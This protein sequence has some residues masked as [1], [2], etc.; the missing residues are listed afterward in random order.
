[1]AFEEGV[2]ATDVPSLQKMGLPLRKVATLISSVFCEQVFSSGF[3][4]CDPHEANVLI[5]G[6]HKGR[7]H[8]PVLVLLDHGL[9]KEL[10]TE[11][12]LDYCRLWK[13]LVLKDMDGVK[14][15]CQKLN[16]G[17]MYSLLAAIL[18]S[19]SW[20]DI[21]SKDLGSLKTPSTKED[22]TLIRSYAQRY[23]FEIVEI[24]N[25]VPREM[26]L[27]LKMN[28]CLRH[29]DRQLGA[30]VNRYGYIYLLPAYPRH[31]RP[32]HP[33]FLPDPTHSSLVTAQESIKAL[34][35]E[36]LKQG[37]WKRQAWG[38]WEYLKCEARI[39]S[40]LAWLWVGGKG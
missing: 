20:D 17:E 40:Y 4:H 2:C 35:R 3:T 34:L 18:T 32:P 33:S 19:R 8:E 14:H 30:P 36:E 25:S 23:Y 38:W 10:P 26:L 16:A 31:P 15:F 7:P 37:G 1:M 22:K 29:I 9:Y 5:R 12:R 24:L 13:A 21:T 28:D 39:K 11:F 6:G 27:L